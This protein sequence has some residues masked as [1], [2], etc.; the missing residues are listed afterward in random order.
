MG[1]AVFEV[2]VGEVW[3]AVMEGKMLETRVMEE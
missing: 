1:V 2:G 3:A